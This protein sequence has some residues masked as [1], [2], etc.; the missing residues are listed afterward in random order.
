MKKI[1]SASAQ[2]DWR[3]RLQRGYFTT[4]LEPYHRSFNCHNNIQM[5]NIIETPRESNQGINLRNK[6][7]LNFVKHVIYNQRLATVVSITS[8]A[9]QPKNEYEIV[10]N[11]LRGQLDNSLDNTKLL[12]FPDWRFLQVRRRCTTVLQFDNGRRRPRRRRWSERRSSGRIYGQRQALRFGNRFWTG[13][14]RW[15]R[16]REE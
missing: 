12:G 10:Q 13:R 8:L 16:S 9:K 6:I 3:L 5:I 4:H 14:R 15:S 2:V 11:Q 1:T 7:H